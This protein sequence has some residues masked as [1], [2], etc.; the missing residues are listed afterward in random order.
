MHATVTVPP[1]GRITFHANAITPKT[2]Y[3]LV[4]G[5]ASASGPSFSCHKTAG[6]VSPAMTH[7]T[8]NSFTA[9]ANPYD[10]SSCSFSGSVTFS[11]NGS[12]KVLV[13]WEQLSAKTS[14]AVENTV[15]RSF[16]AAGTQTDSPGGFTL[17]GLESGDRYRI[18]VTLTDSSNR[19]ITTTAGPISLSSCAGPQALQSPGVASSMTS[20]V[21]PTSLTVSQMQDPMFAYECNMTMKQSFSVSGPGS[22]Q[23]VYYLTSGASVGATYY[24]QN[25]VDFSGPGDATDTANFRMPSGYTYSISAKMNV[26]GDPAHSATS[27]AI[28]VS[29]T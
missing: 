13:T 24:S 10:S 9:S 26:L 12:G 19:S 28:A 17:Q 11:T 8:V 29:C 23:V 6:A 15:T 2:G 16:A 18:S 20:P 5:A 22:V 4:V 1:H 27:T 3:K 7:I 21:S 25:Q 14:S